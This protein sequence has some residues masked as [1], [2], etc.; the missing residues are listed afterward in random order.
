MSNTFFLGLLN[1][2]N[3]KKKS[4]TYKKAR[5]LK[6]NKLKQFYINKL[7]QSKDMIFLLKHC[8]Y[9]SIKNTDFKFVKNGIY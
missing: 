6:Y 8:R 7:Y 3:Y 4:Y 9:N 5:R 1:T 2:S